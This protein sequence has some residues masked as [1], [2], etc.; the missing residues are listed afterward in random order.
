MAVLTRNKFVQTEIAQYLTGYLSDELGTKVS[1]KAVEIDFLRNYHLEDLLVLDKHND[2]IF[3]AKTFNANIAHFSFRKRKIDLKYIELNKMAIHIGYYKNEKVVNY[4]FIEDYFKSADTTSKSK[5]WKINIKNIQLVDANFIQ[6]DFRPADFRNIPYEYNVNYL[7]IRN[8]NG[9]ISKWVID[10][11]GRNIFQIKNLSAIERSGVRIESLSADCIFDNTQITLNK[12][13]LEQ[14]DSSQS[15]KNTGRE[16]REDY[17][18]LLRNDTTDNLLADQL[19]I[20]IANNQKAIEQITYEHFQS[21]KNI[22]D[23]VQ[24]EKFDGIILEVTHRMKDNRPKPNR[25]GLSR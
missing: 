16:L 13:K 15:L 17:F 2:T 24:K 10:D 1:V 8:I 23:S 20:Q 18:K 5:P 12:L 19:L 6:F 21:V 3:Y 7:A 22:C 9:Q 25:L 14:Q 4:Q 11:N